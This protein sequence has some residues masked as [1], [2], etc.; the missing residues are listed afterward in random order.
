[1][2]KP[3]KRFRA[4]YDKEIKW[5]EKAANEILTLPKGVKVKILAYDP[6]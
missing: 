2:K 1:M 3:N 6:V 5:D 4:T